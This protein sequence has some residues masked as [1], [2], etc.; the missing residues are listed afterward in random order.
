METLI[1]IISFGM[2]VAFAVVLLCVPA[3]RHFC[4]R[5]GLT[6]SPNRERKLQSSPVALGGGVAVL[7]GLVS[8]VFAVVA[9]GR[10]V[11]FEPLST[12]SADWYHLLG[13]T[14]C[15]L[16]LGL[17]DDISGVRGRQ[18]LLLQCLIIS[19]LVG[20]GTMVTE[21]RGWGYH[22]DLGVLAFPLTVLWFLIVVNAL[23][24]IDGADGMAS[25]VGCVVCCGLGFLGLQMGAPVSAAI[26]FLLAA[27]MLGF[28]VFNLPPASIYLGDAGSM[29][30]GLV[31]GALAIK[32]NS[33]ESAVLTIAPMALL[34]I[35][36]FDSSAA[37]LR[38]WLTGRSIYATDRAH[39]HHVLDQKYGSR[40][41]LLLVASLCAITTSFSLLSARWN[42]HWIAVLGVLIVICILVLTKSFG[43]AEARLAIG[44]V[45]HLAASFV[46]LPSTLRSKEQFLT[47]PLQ[48]A[49]PWETVWE[50]LL[51]I[52][53]SH[54]LCRIRIN[55]NLPWLHESYHATWRGNEPASEIPTLAFSLPLFSSRSEG[56]PGV[57]VGEVSLIAPVKGVEDYPQLANLMDQIVEV[58]PEVDRIA[59][60]LE[61]ERE[62]QPAAARRVE[63]VV[64]PQP[65][66]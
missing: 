24:L 8:G 7:V 39:L 6:D 41:M 43:H 55:L 54:E 63:P 40:R 50:P 32:S 46:V 57:K 53:E 64:E 36:L 5:L 18:K 59:N 51:E 48:G 17:V 33:Q 23:N 65:V 25:T 15:M 12:V 22:F 60:F 37:I 13:A 30:I 31:M 9:A 66:H 1:I 35:P 52:A 21:L 19:A 16:L 11:G 20:G 45:R 34:A 42:Q 61:V 4:F 58:L 38:R 3:V 14:S 10:I 62:D 47:M 27:S 44:K 26:G 29:S 56:G 2:L 49:G 28:L